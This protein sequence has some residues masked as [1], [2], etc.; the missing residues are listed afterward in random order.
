MEREFYKKISKDTQSSFFHFSGKS[1]DSLFCTCPICNAFVNL[2]NPTD[3]GEYVDL[4]DLCKPLY[5]KLEKIKGQN[6][7]MIL[8]SHSAIKE[9]GLLQNFA[10]CLLSNEKV[11]KIYLLEI[12]Q[13]K[14]PKKV[15][16]IIKK[17]NHKR[18][19]RSEFNNLLENNLYEYEVLY[20]VFKDKYF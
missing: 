7:G 9:I 19:P 20:E 6:E 2:F 17:L 5:E 12:E 1:K 11:K 16:E 8:L 4:C 18:I 14:I 3:P 10:N 13:N 15:P